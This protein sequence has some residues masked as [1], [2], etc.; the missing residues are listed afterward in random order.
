M[1]ASDSFSSIFFLESCSSLVIALSNNVSKS[2]LLKGF[3]TYTWQR[4]KSAGM[5]SKLGFSVVAPISVIQPFSTAPSNESCWD[6][7]NRW[8]S[9]MKSM[10]F[11]V[12]NKVLFFL[13]FSITSL[14][15]ATPLSTALKV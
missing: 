9:S 4:D 10:G 1:S 11:C 8:I 15:A 12:A 7:L 5:T 6:L 3:S 13:A 14:T 2:F